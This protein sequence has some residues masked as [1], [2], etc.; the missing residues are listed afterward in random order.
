MLGLLYSPPPPYPAH[1]VHLSLCT[2]VELTSP[3]SS[4]YVTWCVLRHKSIPTITRPPSLPHS[5]LP[6]HPLHLGSPPGSKPTML[7]SGSSRLWSLSPLN[8]PLLMVLLKCHSIPRAPNTHSWSRRR[9]WLCRECAASNAQVFYVPRLVGLFDCT[10]QP[11]RRQIP[12]QIFRY[13][14]DGYNRIDVMYK[15]GRGRD[16]SDKSFKP[17]DSWETWKKDCKSILKGQCR[18]S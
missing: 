12:A 1:T 7:I 2:P 16:S 14:I 3:S 11:R 15:S 8:S 17:S 6:P 13:W 4:N 9:H 5:L 18:C 10:D